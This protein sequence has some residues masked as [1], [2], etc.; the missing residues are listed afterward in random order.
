[1]KAEMW[2]PVRLNNG[3]EQG[4]RLSWELGESQGHPDARHTG[5]LSDF[6]GH[7][8]RFLDDKLTVIVFVHEAQAKTGAIANRLAEYY[9]A[10]G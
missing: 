3:K 1:M 4:Y 9:S 2:K 5:S 8:V 6:Q 10:V 7:F